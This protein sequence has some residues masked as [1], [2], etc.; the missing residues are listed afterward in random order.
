MSALRGSPQTLRRARS[1]AAAVS[2]ALLALVLGSCG[3]FGVD[4][5]VEGV[6]VRSVG[7]DNHSGRSVLLVEPADRTPGSDPLPLVVV[8]H[9]LGENAED[10]ARLLPLA[11]GRP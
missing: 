2:L 3:L 5:G 9:G 10:M 4:L 7:I 11:R 6:D 1:L 8:L